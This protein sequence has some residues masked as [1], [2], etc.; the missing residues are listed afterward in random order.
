[1]GV[2]PAFV[3]WR[4][5]DERVSIADYSLFP[6]PTSATVRVRYDRVLF[7]S[8]AEHELDLDL[9]GTAGITNIAPDILAYGALRV[10]G[11][12]HENL[13][14]RSQPR[15]TWSK[16]SSNDPTPKQCV[17]VVIFTSRKRPWR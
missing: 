12:R 10:R 17:S 9:D 3:V 13:T 4:F 16:Y 6:R 8:T 11:Q 7:L 15:S 5:R 14:R 1:M 2:P